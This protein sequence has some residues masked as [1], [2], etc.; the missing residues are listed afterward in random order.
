M[1]PVSGLPDEVHSVEGG[2][3]VVVGAGGGVSGIGSAAGIGAGAS[4]GFG[5]GAI[6][7]FGFALFFAVLLAFFFAPFFAFRFFAKQLHRPIVEVQMVISLPEN[8]LAMKHSR[9]RGLSQSIIGELCFGWRARPEL[10]AG[11][12]CSTM[13][14][15]IFESLNSHAAEPGNETRCV[16]LTATMF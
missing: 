15:R 13:C 8:F 14:T 5:G 11:L 1:D 7:F 9:V 2:C 10:D 4:A 6:F 12:V 16:M 3:S